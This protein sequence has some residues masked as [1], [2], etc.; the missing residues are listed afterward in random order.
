MSAGPILV[1]G[2]CGQLGWELRRALAPLGPVRA[3]DVDEMPLEDTA[4]IRRL[5]R[6][7]RPALCVNAAAYTAVDRAEEEAEA[8][9]A[10]NGVA[11]AVLADEMK[12]LGGAIV[13]Y[14]TDY[15]FDGSKGSPYDEEDA[16]RPLSVYGET[17][18]A[19]EEGVR[20]S[21]VPHLIL[22][23]SWVYGA[24]GRN[25]L[26]TM[27]GLMAAG[28]PLRVVNDQHGAPT[29]CRLLAEATAL[30]LAQTGAALRPEA[31]E[32]FAG[33]YHLACTGAT[34]WH[35]FAEAIREL[36]PGPVR[37]A[38]AAVAPV[39]TA[40]YPAKAPRP[41]NSRLDCGR[42]RD[43]FGLELPD[44]KDALRLVMEDPGLTPAAPGGGAA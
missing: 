21:G 13:H 4:A 20:G 6:A 43:T 12:R 42:F 36:A 37:A 25:F 19:G 34:T 32:D 38:A 14:S 24:R 44:W 10:V 39:A 29:W 35:G 27:L 17:K 9:M 30:A 22:R 31:L 41:A 1:T 18:L 7:V 11:P 28:R 40:A 15:V 23:T 5:V 2:A 8:A 16:P 3:V 33:T 26:R